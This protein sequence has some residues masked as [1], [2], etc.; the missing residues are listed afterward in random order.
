MFTA[1]PTQRGLGLA[2]TR[3]LGV[4]CRGDRLVKGRAVAAE[5][6]AVSPRLRWVLYPSV[7][8]DLPGDLRR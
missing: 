2:A 4:S 1:S 3:S 7:L 6:V 8:C 5:L